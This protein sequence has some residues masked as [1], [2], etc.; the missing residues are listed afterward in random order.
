[1]VTVVK[2]DF[3]NLGV[4]YP[5]LGTLAEKIEEGLVGGERR[6]KGRLFS[7][8]IYGKMTLVRFSRMVPDTT[9]KGKKLLFHFLRLRKEIGKIIV[10]D[11]NEP[12]LT[13]QA[14]ILELLDVGRL[15]KSER[16]ENLQLRAIFE[17]KLRLA[18][19]QR[20]QDTVK[21]LWPHRHGDDKVQLDG[22]FKQKVVDRRWV[23]DI[24]ASL[25]SDE[26][27]HTVFR[28][29]SVWCPATCYNSL[30][31]VADHLDSLN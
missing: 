26:D 9:Y 24:N 13:T 27:T 14:S 28:V 4:A 20:R 23:C 10:P 29:G 2:A 31:Q 17:A 7:P 5:E 21:H 6:L 25:P 3:S 30:V 16:I 19:C 8:Q 18:G 22:R 11:K 12:F 1:M 15:K